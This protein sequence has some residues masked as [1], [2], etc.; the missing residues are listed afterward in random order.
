MLSPKYS[1]RR[2][3]WPKIMLKWSASKFEQ[4]M[5]EPVQNLR[6]LSDVMSVVISVVMSF[7]I[8]DVTYNIMSNVLSDV[9]SDSMP[10]VM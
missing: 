2:F 1:K 4:K 7:V 6:H 3:V 8:S 10:D 9:I 5:L